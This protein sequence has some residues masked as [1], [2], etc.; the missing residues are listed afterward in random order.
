MCHCRAG[1]VRAAPLPNG[2]A[3]EEGAVHKLGQDSQFMQQQLT[4]GAMN[5]LEFNQRALGRQKAVLE[6]GTIVCLY[7]GGRKHRREWVRLARF[8]LEWLLDG[9]T[10][11]L[12]EVR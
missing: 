10:P 2:G 5:S 12:S 6:D 11:I 9:Q 1:V 8:K 3:N 4:T 7:E